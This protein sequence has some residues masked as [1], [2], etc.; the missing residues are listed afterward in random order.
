MAKTDLNLVVIFDAIM[1]EQSVTAAAERLA[2][3]QPSVS[4]A[5]SRMRHV[6]RDPLF[7]KDGR[8]IRP[9]PY[10]ERLW[11]QIAHPLSD[12]R[13]A[14]NPTAF[15]PGSH[16]RCF[17]IALTDGL[18][19]MFWTPLRQFIENNAPN[20]DIHAVPYT[21]ALEQQLMSADVD[22]VV[23]HYFGR[24][25]HIAA[26]ALFENPFV[27]VM[28]PDHALTQG[29]LTLE[30][31]V[32]ADQLLVSLSGD[33]E[34]SVDIALA[35]KGLKRRLAMTLNTFAGAAELVR[36]TQLITVLPY[37]V[38]AKYLQRGELVAR[39]APLSIPT[40]MM[41]MAWHKRDERD[42][43]ILWLRGVIQAI[44]DQVNDDIERQR[45]PLR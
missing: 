40:P 20:I 9:T 25:A 31:F 28:R 29:A 11:R 13:D 5:L 39:A 4:N 34:G 8:G 32:A 23:G 19:G 15:D 21:G 17:R 12:I 10:A 2:M 3:T 41:Y 35:E 18:T 33:A 14:V 44:T 43:A 42:P 22:M 30:R 36:E 6:W 27:V 1:R 24:H 37:P 7:V 16:Q 45:V 38:V 26:R